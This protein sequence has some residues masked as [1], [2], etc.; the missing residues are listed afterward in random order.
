MKGDVH[1]VPVDTASDHNNMS[2]VCWCCPRY[3]LPCD[4]CDTG[5]WKCEDGHIVLTGEEAEK[6][7]RPIVIV[8]NR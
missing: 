7:T 6:M 8:H 3:L 2:R 5:C 1:T 4:E